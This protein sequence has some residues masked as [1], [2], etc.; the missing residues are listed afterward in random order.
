MDTKIAA[1]ELKKLSKH[2]GHQIEVD[3]IWLV[4]GALGLVKKATAKHLEKI[5]GK[6]NLADIGL[7][8]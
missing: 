4:V 7:S 3:R 8:I 2:K 5:L 6:Q 1:K